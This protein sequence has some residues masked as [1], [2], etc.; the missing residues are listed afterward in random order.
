MM[1]SLFLSRVLGML[2]DSVMF[3]H[4]PAG[5]ATDAYGI[6]FTIPD[7]LFMLIA[8]GGLSSAFIPVFSEYIHT[9]REDDA[10]NVF[11]VVTTVSSAV[12]IGLI[13]IA[14]FCAPLIAGY[15]SSGKMHLVNGVSVPVGPEFVDQVAAMSRIMLPAQFAFLIG[16]ILLGTLY[17]RHRLAAPGLAPNIYNAGIIGG[18]IAGPILGIGIFGMCWGVLIGAVVGNLLIPIAMMI[19]VG[20]RYRIDFRLKTPGV[21]KFFKL[22][23]PVILGFSLPSVCGIITTKFAAMESE[24][25]VSVL[26][27][28]NNLMQAPL[29]IFGH[30]LALAAFPVLSQFFAQGDMRRYRDQVSKTMRTTIYLCFPAAAIMLAAAPQIVHV[31]YEYG[32][33][34]K[35]VEANAQI[36]TSLRIFSIGVVAWCVQPVLMRG[37]FS[38]QKTLKPILLST[39]MTALFILL[40]WGNM[41]SGLGY[42]GLPWATNIA[43]TLL[44]VILYVALEREVGKLDRPK[45]AATLILCLAAASV[46]AGFVYGA[47]QLI[48]INHMSRLSSIATFMFIVVLGAWLYYFLTKAFGMDETDYVSRAMNKINRKTRP[49]SEAEAGTD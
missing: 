6:A 37:F 41:Y 18:A 36:A 15:V 13:T 29:G 30:A 34:A 19:W 49:I 25:I 35:N 14:W 8:G 1:F 31:L 38:V 7:L 39:G 32:A 23:L 17:A 11:S 47:F 16:S 5:L 42:V 21:S 2:R 45:I 33:Q 28:S 44:A 46:M 24:G 43:A 9:D 26:R 40:C 20:S 48:S 4:F 27:A 22:L 10:W 12:V 3:A